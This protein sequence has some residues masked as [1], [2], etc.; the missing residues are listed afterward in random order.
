MRAQ[1]WYGGFFFARDPNRLRLPDTTRLRSHR[2][3]HHNRWIG[4]ASHLLQDAIWEPNRLDFIIGDCRFIK[5]V[6]L[7]AFFIPHSTTFNAFLNFDP[8]L[9]RRWMCARELPPRSFSSWRQQEEDEDGE[10]SCVCTSYGLRYVIG[11]AFETKVLL[12]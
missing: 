11:R 6:A 9:G 4:F 3:F 12:S 10:L 8:P 5:V 7:K 2:A 1:L